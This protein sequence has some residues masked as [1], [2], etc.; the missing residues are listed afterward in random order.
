M[1][2][3]GDGIVL[4]ARSCR[5]QWPWSWTEDRTWSAGRSP[6][7]PVLAEE[8]YGHPIIAVRVRGKILVFE[9]TNEA[10]HKRNRAALRHRSGRLIDLPGLSAIL[11]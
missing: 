7:S 10:G 1:A 9:E 11:Y 4:E 6:F 2:M 3:K 8:L 5:G